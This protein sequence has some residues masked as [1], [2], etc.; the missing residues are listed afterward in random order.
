[1]KIQ[2]HALCFNE[3][4]LSE[5]FIKHY[6]NICDSIVIHDNMSTDGCDEILATNKKVIIEKY[7]SNLC[8]DNYKYID[9]KNNS[10]KKYRKEYDWMIICDFDEFLYHPNLI[11]MLEKFKEEGVSIPSMVGF[12]MISLEFPTYENKQIYEKMQRG[13]KS[14]LFSKNIIFDPKLIDDINYCIGA[15]YIYPTGVVKYSDEE[16]FLLHYKYLGYDYC[17]EKCNQ[18]LKRKYTTGH[19]LYIDKKKAIEKI[20]SNAKTDEDLNKITSDII[21]NIE[22]KVYKKPQTT[23]I[24]IMDKNQNIDNL[25][26]LLENLSINIINKNKNIDIKIFY[27]VDVFKHQLYHPNIEYI[28]SAKIDENTLKKYLVETSNKYKFFIVLKD[29]YNVTEE[30][31]NIEKTETLICNRH[32]ICG[33]TNEVLQNLD[34]IKTKNL[35]KLMGRK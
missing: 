32:Y 8:I 19:H 16:L 30:M 17:I 13:W 33:K 28:F 14:S 7:D 29:I 10:W 20:Y 2:L 15:H 22:N 11:A 21:K 25:K 26:I 35:F 9:I 34:R 6:D 31:L 24:S 18:Y 27:N 4:P 23:I 1:M 12:E 5:Y 3:K